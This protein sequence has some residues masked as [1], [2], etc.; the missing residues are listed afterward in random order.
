MGNKWANIKQLNQINNKP[1]SSENQSHNK[2][3]EYANQRQQQQIHI[4][5]KK[6][7]FFF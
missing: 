3:H 2:P 7:I 6:K 4:F 5:L 1:S